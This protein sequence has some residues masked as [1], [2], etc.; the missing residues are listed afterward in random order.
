VADLRFPMA[1]APSAPL[2]PPPGVEALRAAGPVSR[3]LLADGR[4][5]WL[6]TGHAEAR[7]LAV[8]DR[9]SSD[10][11][12][13]GYPTLHAGTAHS[14]ARVPL[15]QSD[16]P[17]HGRWR[18][19]VAAEFTEAAALAMGPRIDAITADLV[20]DLVRAGPPGDLVATVAKPLPTLVMCEL[21]GVPVASRADFHAYA[22]LNFAAAPDPPSLSLAYLTVV[23]ELSDLV[24]ERT[25]RPRDDLISRIVQR[26]RESGADITHEEL[27]TFVCMLLVTGT[28]STANVLATSLLTVLDR[29]ALWRELVADRGHGRF[30]AVVD[31][32]LRY[33][34]VSRGM[35]RVATAPV[36]IAGVEI[37]EGDGVVLAFDL[38]NRDPAAY[39]GPG[40]FDPDRAG[41]PHLTFG[42]GRHL[43]LGR[44]L[45]RR[46]LGSL[47]G[48]LPGTLPELRLACPVA[49]LTFRQDGYLFGADALPVTW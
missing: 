15:V 20:G 2:A 45:A 26:V 49:S 36:A 39:A 19:L 5:A 27:V 35:S 48:C 29:P 18:R 38:A 30:D 13:P 32:I 16:G 43:C 14:T 6:V 34:P 31:E 11:R 3:V 37:A 22:E 46:E 17:E 44:H 12:R 47:L 42:H 7:A 41:V 1:P 4:P 8:D 40:T 21:L 24:E 25:A 33:I 10:P 9:L 23:A 28:E